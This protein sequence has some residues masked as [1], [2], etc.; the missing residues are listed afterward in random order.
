MVFCLFSDK[1][2][3]NAKG[4]GARG[5]MGNAMLEKQ[6][7]PNE[8]AVRLKNAPCKDPLACGVTCIFGVC[9]FP[10]CYFR[11]AVLEKFG[12]GVDD[13]VCCQGYVP[14]MCCIDFPTCCQGSAVG[15]CLEG[16]CCPFFS[17]SIA[18]LHI[19]DAKQVRPDP[20]DWQIIAF[21]NCLQLLSC[22]CDVLACFMEEFRELAAI[23]DCI[24]DVVTASVAGCARL[25]R[26][27]AAAPPAP[28]TIVQS[29]VSADSPFCLL[30]LCLPP[31]RGVLCA[32]AGMGAQINYELKSAPSVGAI[33]P[34]AYPKVM[35]R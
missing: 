9:G 16:C 18:R 5:A 7:Y 31:P 20:M 12:R 8:F 26:A 11:K 23:I 34:V 4:K 15:L 24:A 32:S 2:P 3:P 21:S 1:P 33:P 17:L 10:A 6:G 28:A 25:S 22:F 35:A 14:K 30:P 13:Y 19:M 27:P 29:R